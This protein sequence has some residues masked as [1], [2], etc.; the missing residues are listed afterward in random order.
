VGAL[1][2]LAVGV[3]AELLAVS[4][5]VGAGSVQICVWC[6][7]TG[8][9]ADVAAETERV[10]LLSQKWARLCVVVGSVAAVRALW[11]EVGEQVRDVEAGG[12]VG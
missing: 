5:G 10:A 1:L 3:V 11:V 4:L 8:V 7:Q 6:W 12:E 2:S 9:V